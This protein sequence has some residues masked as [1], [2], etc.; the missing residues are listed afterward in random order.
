MTTWSVSAYHST[1]LDGVAVY[2]HMLEISLPQN[3]QAA[4]HY[5]RL[6][7]LSLDNLVV[8]VQQSIF[9]CVRK[10]GYARA[11]CRSKCSVFSSTPCSIICLATV[12]RGS[13]LDRWVT[14][15]RV[16]PSSGCRKWA[17]GRKWAWSRTS[18]INTS[19]SISICCT[20]VTVILT[21]TSYF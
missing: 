5:F 17:R 4:F 14:G 18:L 15:A 21:G 9:N 10:S 2:C 20:S 7:T 3:K 6:V 16:T 11:V 13:S 12:R 19:V 8:E 1:P